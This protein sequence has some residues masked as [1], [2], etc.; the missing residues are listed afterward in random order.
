[1]TAK[2]EMFVNEDNIEAISQYDSQR[3][4]I[5]MVSGNSHIAIGRL[6]EFDGILNSI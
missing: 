5:T 4:Q 6:C 1:M 3:V 2:G